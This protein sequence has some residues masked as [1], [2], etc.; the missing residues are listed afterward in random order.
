MKVAIICEYSGTVRD[1]F[2]KLG[3]DAISFDI[4]PT[5]TP[6][7]HFQESQTLLLNNGG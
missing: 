5:E 3:H 4:L 6:G 2:T 1:A 7:E